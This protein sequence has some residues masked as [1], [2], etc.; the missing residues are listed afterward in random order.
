MRLVPL[1]RA[2]VAGLSWPL[3]EDLNDF[4]IESRLY[5]GQQTGPRPQLDI[6]YVAA[7]FAVQR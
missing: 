2:V 6:A 5:P 3:P 7:S 4:A 1:R